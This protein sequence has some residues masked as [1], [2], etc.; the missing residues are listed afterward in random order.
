MAESSGEKTEQ[1]TGKKLDDARKE[2][3]VPQSKEV[4]IAV[5]LVISFYGFKI[6]Y[7][8]MSEQMTGCIK[9][10]LELISY[11]ESFGVSDAQTFFIKGL[12]SYGLAAFPLLLIVGF[13]AIIVTFA[14]TKGL[15]NFKSLRP[16]FSKMNPLSGLKKLVSPKGFMEVL[17]SVLKIIL[18]IIVI[19]ISIKNR[20]PELP[21]LI[22]GD[23][24]S[25]AEFTGNV[26]FDIINKTVIAFAAVALADYIYQRFNY[27]K[28]LR[29]TKQE[30][31][32]EFKQMEGDPQI[33]GKIKQKQREVSQRRMMQDVPSADVII[34]NPTHYAVA[35]KYDHEH[36]NAPVVIA[37]GTD[38]IAL[39][40]VEIGE[41]NNVA[42]VE[43]VPLARALYA[44]VEIGSEI[45]AEFYNSVA[46]VLAYV[47][48]LEKKDL[49]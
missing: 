40:I 35:L 26:I 47:F 21:K 41:N 36:S 44:A 42:V 3:N 46:E 19:Y 34:R 9:E 43:N 22:D 10:Y 11:Q 24:Y 5:T 49:N 39:K 4:T 48:S 45:P 8:F 27:I 6:L 12:L 37:K 31:K 15:V 2:G 18:L 17:K 33:K 28:Q 25:A 38:R 1:P 14:Q 20:I 23:I 7:N 16:K 29:M 30:V 32:E 13:A